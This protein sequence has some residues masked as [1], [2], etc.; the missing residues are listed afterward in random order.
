MDTE[1]AE[2]SGVFLNSSGGEVSTPLPT[3]SSSS[4]NV[5]TVFLESY[6]IACYLRGF[7][8]KSTNIDGTS[9]FLEWPYVHHL[10]THSNSTGCSSLTT[11]EL[12]IAVTPGTHTGSSKPS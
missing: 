12:E 7:M 4:E 8:D 2:D 3:L 1:M 5:T 10:S 6:E 11:S 9:K